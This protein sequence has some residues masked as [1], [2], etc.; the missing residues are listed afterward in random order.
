M[1]GCVP[2]FSGWHWHDTHTHATAYTRGTYSRVHTQT[3]S[4]AQR[5][6]TKYG[7][8][9]RRGGAPP[10]SEEGASPPPPA[11][12]INLHLCRDLP[13]RSYVHRHAPKGAV[14]AARATSTSTSSLHS[15]TAAGLACSAPCPESVGRAAPPARSSR[16]GYTRLVACAAVRRWLC[17]RPLGALA[18]ACPPR[19]QH[20]SSPVSIV[21]STLR[22]RGPNQSKQCAVPDA[23]LWC[24]CGR[25]DARAFAIAVHTAL[26]LAV[27]AMH[28]GWRS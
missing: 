19:R 11:S 20:A 15:R 14:P 18:R 26:G 16:P 7:A 5:G 3:H 17:S 10:S 25:H 21:R 1:L 9:S 2:A 13:R 6:P 4:H 24:L 27:A 28:M 12:C 8:G 22:R 23:E